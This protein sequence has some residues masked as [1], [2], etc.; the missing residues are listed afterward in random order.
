[1][2]ALL[3]GI[4]ITGGLVLAAGLWAQ[5][6]ESN[7]TRHHPVQ[8]AE[9]R[10]AGQSA[11]AAVREIV[12]I[13]E[14]DPATDWSKVDVEALRRHLIDMMQATRAAPDLAVEVISRSTEAR[15]RR[16]KAEL[17][18]RFGIPEYWIV[19]PLANTIEVY[20]NLG[21]QYVLSGTFG[22]G[23]EVASPTLPGLR[24]HASRVFAQ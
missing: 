11:F 1:M 4:L 19:D 22:E 12:G 5:H 16:R 8:A 21:G 7:A 10:E 9:P 3:S 13:L 24:F 2:R 20:T 15:D 6:R 14:A 17:F 18:A 23:Q